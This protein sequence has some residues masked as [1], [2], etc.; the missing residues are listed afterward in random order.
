MANK[1]L[2]KLLD[3]DFKPIKTGID[4]NNELISININ[5]TSYEGSTIS[6]SAP[7]TNNVKGWVE[8]I[9]NT[10]YG[11]DPDNTIYLVDA[12]DISS[13][14]IVNSVKITVDKSTNNSTAVIG[15]ISADNLLSVRLT[16]EKEYLNTPL[17]DVLHDIISSVGLGGTLDETYPFALP[18]D[19]DN[20]EKRYVDSVGLVINIDNDVNV[21][22]STDYETADTPVADLL[23]TYGKRMYTTY[24]AILNK[25]IITID[26][27]V[28]KTADNAGLKYLISSE[29][30]NIKSIE[31][32]LNREERVN[33]IVSSDKTYTNE[34]ETNIPS[35]LNR[36]EYYSTS[37]DSTETDIIETEVNIEFTNADDS[38]EKIN[39]SAEF[40]AD[41]NFGLDS[42]QVYVG[43]QVSISLYLK[44]G[45]R[46]IVDDVI[47]EMNI[48]VDKTK[49]STITPTYIPTIGYDSTDDDGNYMTVRQ[50]IYYKSNKKVQQLV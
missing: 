3:K 17:S 28:D 42:N 49:T 18:G 22:Y 11:A 8:E 41:F 7:I 36:V 39:V 2:M 13:F 23:K 32:Q 19:E 24:N 37:S 45:Q 31:Y 30:E 27:G 5:K 48:V 12:N 16:T 40:G 9:K 21:D 47:S 33:V 29:N 34:D 14:F 46:V 50:R 25:L 1:L 20:R 26:D 6:I 38:T 43:D 35:G 4:I 15:G 10:V 44:D